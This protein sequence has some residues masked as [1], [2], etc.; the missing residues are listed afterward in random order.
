MHRNNAVFYLRLSKEDDKLGESASIENQREILHQYLQKTQFIFSGE[1]V[2]DGY[3]GTNMDRPAFKQMIKDIESG[4]VGVVLTKDFSRLGRNSGRVQMVIDEVFL[5]NRVRYIAVSDGIDTAQRNGASEIIA[6]V[7]GFANELYASDISR[8]IK[9][10]FCAKMVKGDYI[11]AFAPFGYKK[12]PENRN[13]LLPD[14]EA[15]KTVQRIFSLA[16]KGCSP[17]ETAKKL[18]SEKVLTPSKYRLSKNPH[19]NAGSFKL[20]NN[21]QAGM[22]GRIL[23]NEVYLGKTIQGKTRKPSFKMKYTYTVPKEERITVNDTHIPLV[24]EETWQIVRNRARSRNKNGGSGFV[25]IFSGIAKC[26]DCGK[27][28]STTSS[29]KKGSL[30]NLECGGYKLNGRKSCTN[31]LI[32]YGRLCQAVFGALKKEINFEKNKRIA[33]YDTDKLI[34]AGSF[35]T[36]ILFELIDRIDVHQGVYENGVKTQE[37][38]IMFK[39]RCEEKSFEI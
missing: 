22:V 8:K 36:D 14:A 34:N 27:N 10:S 12:D 18:N 24:D 1:Y 6:P 33:E 35:D 9:S 37:I 39:F 23:R 17:G 13:R 30:A 19:I 3:S 29:R 25:N 2:D 38:D 31:H 4:K 20:Q 21:W 5:K 32:D 15:A 16:K 26:A 11:G 7:L 28:M